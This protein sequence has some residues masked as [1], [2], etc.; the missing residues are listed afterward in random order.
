MSRFRSRKCLLINVLLDIA[1]MAQ[2]LRVGLLS[3][4][5]GDRR[6]DRFVEARVNRLALEAM[7]VLCLLYTSRCV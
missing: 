1:E 3:I 2:H 7:R 6:G 5:G 4:A